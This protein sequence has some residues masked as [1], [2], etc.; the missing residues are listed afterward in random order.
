MADDKYRPRPGETM[1]EY[2]DRTGTPFAIL[3]WSYWAEKEKRE[4]D[5]S[6]D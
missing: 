5:I 1:R 3:D 4:K 2:S 6:E